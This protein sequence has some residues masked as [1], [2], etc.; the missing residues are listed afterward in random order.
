MVGRG[1]QSGVCY[2]LV[3]VIAFIFQP[4]RTRQYVST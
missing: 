1:V 4:G 2:R 3:A